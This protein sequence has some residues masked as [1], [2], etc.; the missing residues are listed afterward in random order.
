M[1]KS[2]GHKDFQGLFFEAD[3][4]LAPPGRQA[5]SKGFPHKGSPHRLPLPRVMR[6][7][8]IISVGVL[9][10][11]WPKP[12]ARAQQALVSTLA[13]DAIIQAQQQ[14][15]LLAESNTNP[16]V[17]LPPDVPHLGPVLWNLGVYSSIESDDNIYLS[18]DNNESDL[19]LG[20]GLD[21][22]L[23]W[24]ATGRSAL[25]FNS[26]LGY[27]AYLQHPDFNYVQISPGSALTWTFTLSDWDFTFFDQL[28][29]TRSVVAVASVSNLGGIPLFDNTAGARAQWHPGQWLL[30]TGYS[31][32]E[33]LSTSTAYKYLSFGADY[34]YARGGWRFSPNGTLGIESSVS[35]T[36]YAEPVQP[37]STSYS[38]GPYLEWQLDPAVHVSLHGGPTFYKFASVSSGTAQSSLTSYY[39]SF[40]V[41]HKFN[42]FLSED[43]TIDRS[44][45]PSYY[46]GSAFTE[47]LSAAYSVSWYAKTW[48]SFNLGLNYEKGQQ[49]LQEITQ[50]YFPPFGLVNELQ[51]ITE[52]FDRYGFN[53]GANYQL[54]EYISAGVNYAHWTRGSNIADNEYNDDQISAQLR[55]NF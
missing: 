11:L 28:N 43:L 35:I 22:G 8:W 39:V 1:P 45:S 18:R 2:L 42:Q 27:Y 49:P 20:S 9:C 24:Q 51:N 25:Q 40:E 29:Y 48:L 34:L 26:Q 55:Y 21:L 23:N 6:P 36:D 46:Q 10:C 38:V 33:H 15:A 41:T 54:T 7:P 12:A 13:L 5:E 53:L 3:P 4:R 17:N 50:V 32:D 47:Q 37:N 52:N 44:V 30:E 16:V 14:A 31:Y 19:I